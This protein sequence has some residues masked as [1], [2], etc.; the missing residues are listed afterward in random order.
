MDYIHKDLRYSHSRRKVEF[1]IFIPN[2]SLAFEYQ[3][4]QH[5][6]DHYLFGSN[7]SLSFRDTQKKVIYSSEPY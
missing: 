1:D 2:L 5:Y 7:Y 4:V 6:G 3:G